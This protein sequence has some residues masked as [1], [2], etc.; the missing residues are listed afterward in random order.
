MLFLSQLE[1]LNWL[2][3]SLVCLHD[4]IK[5]TFINEQKRIYPRPLPHLTTTA[6]LPWNV[7]LSEWQWFMAYWTECSKAVPDCSQIDKFHDIVCQHHILYFFFYPDLQDDRY[8]GQMSSCCCTLSA[9]LWPRGCHIMCHFFDISS[10]F[11]LKVTAD[12]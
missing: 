10:L 3:K 9:T 12:V 4:S 7:I 5:Q 11:L 8:A 2:L 6:L 1:L